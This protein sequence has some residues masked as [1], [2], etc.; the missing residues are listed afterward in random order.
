MGEVYDDFGNL[1]SSSLANTNTNSNSLFS[2]NQKVDLGSA[3]SNAITQ[4]AD[5][6]G[7]TSALT[8]G[9]L[10]STNL[11]AAAD[12]S[13]NTSALTK[14]DT[15]GIPGGLDVNGIKNWINNN[16]E[17]VGLAGAGLG[18]MTNVSNKYGTT[19]YQ[20]TIPELTATRNMVTAP[21]TKAQG[22]RPGAGGIN[23]GGDVTYT[24]TPGVDPWVNLSGNSGSS[25]GAVLTDTSGIAGLAGAKNTAN[26]GSTGY[27]NFI[28][29]GGTPQGYLQTINAWLAANPNVTNAQLQAKMQELGVTQTDLQT[30]LGASG[31]SAAEKYALSHGMGSSGVNDSINNWLAKYPNATAQQITDAMKTVG[32]S[33]ADITDAFNSNPK[34]SSKADQWNIMNGKGTAAVNSSINNFL[35]LYPNATQA[36]KQAAM[37]KYGITQQDVAEAQAIPLQNKAAAIARK[38]QIP[39]EK[40]LMSAFQLAETKDT[41]PGAIAKMVANSGLST[42]QLAQDF[43][44]KQAD[45]DYLRNQ[46]YLPAGYE[47]GGKVLAPGLNADGTWNKEDYLARHVAGQVD[48]QEQV[49]AAR[50]ADRADLM[51]G[52]HQSAFDDAGV[53]HMLTSY[54]PGFDANDPFTQA[55]LGELNWRTGGTDTTSKVAS[56]TP[57][58]KAADAAAWEKDWNRLNAQDVKNG[59]AGAITGGGMPKTGAEA[60]TIQ[61]GLMRAAQ[62]AAAKKSGVNTSLIGMNP[63]GT[64]IL[65]KAMGGSIDM[66]KGRYLQGGTDGM[67]DE[68][69]AQIGQDQP[70]ALSHGE[71]VVPADVVSHLG[72]GNSDAGAKKLYQMM[73]K[74][75]MARTGNKKQGK[76]INPDKFMPGGLAAAYAAGGAVQKFSGENTNSLVSANSQANTTPGIA[77]VESNLSNWAGPYVTNM[78]GQG[79]ALANMPYQ[80]YMGPLTAGESSLQT[81]GYQTAG[82]LSVPSSIGQAATAA[83]NIGTAAQGLSY[84]PT[85]TSFDATQASQ[86]MNP[87]L[88]TSLQPQLDEARRQ[89]QITQAQNASKMTQAGAF[90]GGRQAILDAET[91]RSLGANLANI[92]GQGYNTAYT[93][94]QQQFNADQQRKMQEAQYGAGFGLQGLQAGLQA[95]TAQGA[96]GTQENQAGINTLNAQLGAGAQQRG[97]ES[98]GIAADKA[99]FEEARANPYKMVQYQQSLLQGLP[100]DAKSYT[101]IQQSDIVKA[102]QGAT[103]V[104]QLLKNLGL[105]T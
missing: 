68:I 52:P 48:T 71:F 15:A 60:N 13:G 88:Q 72:N 18:L 59:I 32:M 19:G 103:T 73:D 39:T 51:K 20:G 64:D 27:Q 101:G 86:Y 98:E 28:K 38:E 10:G 25:A 74:I 77:G 26:V 11:T 97:I 56:L 57:E 96:L 93:N 62:L 16:K 43:G 94:A 99:Q 4:N 65:G 9:N 63:F 41:D 24:R 105:I 49:D 47:E 22:Y 102:A 92:T 35:A 53:E 83:G 7:N 66:A 79:Q 61:Q 36:E 5:N 91:Q 89:S 87:Y 84:Q 2:D 40:D 50:A 30:A 29:S 58:Q 1:L 44:L 8:G 42:A 69:P 46:G 100:L 80:A 70:A 67:S 75:R 23:Y 55:R 37:D 14:T 82:D 81:K 76:R 85:T 78:L 31:F 3:G 33:M 17:L 21:P 54:M 95:A 12:N 34:L 6:S 45:L 104:N 90:G